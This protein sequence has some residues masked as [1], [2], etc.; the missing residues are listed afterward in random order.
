[1]AT[2]RSGPRERLFARE[3]RRDRHPSSNDNARSLPRTTEGEVAQVLGRTRIA[4]IRLTVTLELDEAAARR[5]HA[6]AWDHVAT[7][8]AGPRA[9][10]RASPRG[11]GAPRGPLLG[12]WCPLHLLTIELGIGLG[13]GPPTQARRRTAD[14]IRKRARFDMARTVRPPL[15]EVV[16]SSV[17]RGRTTSRCL[18]DRRAEAEGGERSASS[19]KGGALQRR[20]MMR[21][22]A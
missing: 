8:A 16:K 5:V 4:G 2:P 20:P 21:A 9:P 14:A 7:C 22:D 11:S 3:V 15:N 19:A 12:R 6:V 13:V 17:A 10:Q 1:M 18:D